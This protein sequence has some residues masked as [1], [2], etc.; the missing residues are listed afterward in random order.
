MLPRKKT[1]KQGS[2]RYDWVPS[3]VFSEAG[4]TAGVRTTHI[5]RKSIRRFDSYIGCGGEARGIATCYACTSAPAHASCCSA[6]YARRAADAGC[7][8]SAACVVFHF[9]PASR[10]TYSGCHAPFNG[11]RLFIL[12]LRR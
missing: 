7:G 2:L 1:N 8:H 5:A 4:G 9:A 11:R 6:T 10:K 3:T 12:Q